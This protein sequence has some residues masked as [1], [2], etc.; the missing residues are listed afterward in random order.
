MASFIWAKF[1]EEEDPG[2][3]PES[4]RA[5]GEGN[6]NL[7]Q[8][9]CLRNPIDRGTWWAAVHAVMRVFSN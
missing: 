5:P 4:G 2:S 3:V 7:L 8:Y 1:E 6:I 9:S